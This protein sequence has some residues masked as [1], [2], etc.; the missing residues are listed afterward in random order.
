MA[1]DPAGRPALLCRPALDSRRL[2][3]G[4]PH[5]RRQQ[6]GRVPLPPAAVLHPLQLDA[7]RR[8]AGE[9]ADMN[10][11]I[12]QRASLPL[13]LGEGRGEG[14]PPAPQAKPFPRR[15]RAKF[16]A[17]TL[18]LIAYIVFALLPIYWM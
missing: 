7:A 3:P 16:R 18:F 8:H 2:L 15:E 17:R 5:R 14:T 12:A 13:P 4:G 10:T 11:D 9:R 1:L 6:A